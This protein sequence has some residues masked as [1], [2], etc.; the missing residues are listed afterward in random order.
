MP[1][2]TLD[3]VQPRGEIVIDRNYEGAPGRL[4]A[5]NEPNLMTAFGVIKQDVLAVLACGTLDNGI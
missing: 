1:V 5:F 4:F 2:Q 3:A